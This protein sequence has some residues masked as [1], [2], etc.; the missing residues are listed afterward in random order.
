[1]LLA[2]CSGKPG[3][4][5]FKMFLAEVLK[6]CSGAVE[7][8]NIKQVHAHE[9]EKDVYSVDLEFD[10]TLKK[11]MNLPVDAFMVE[12]SKYTPEELCVFRNFSEF[13]KGSKNRPKFTVIFKKTEKGW[14]GEQ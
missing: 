13:K 1:L 11:D 14:K 6:D 9:M 10:L 5:D 2:G 12:T 4:S 8:S 3:D 7:I